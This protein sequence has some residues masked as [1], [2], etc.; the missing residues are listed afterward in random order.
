[1]C[2]FFNANVCL[3]FT[4]TN[5]NLTKCVQYTGFQISNIEIAYN[6]EINA[7]CL[8]ISW[9][10]GTGEKRKSIFKSI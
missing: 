8:N 9:L 2:F 5:S 3:Y 7:I 1:M 10:D 6:N 4:Q